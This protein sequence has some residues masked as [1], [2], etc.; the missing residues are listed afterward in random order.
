VWQ[1]KGQ[2]VPADWLC[3]EPVAVLYD[4]D[5][6]TIFT[7]KDVDGKLYLAYQCS[8]APGRM[9]FLVVP[10]SEESVRRLSIGDLNLHDALMRPRACLIDLDYQG[11]VLAAWETLPENLPPKAIPA[12][13]VMLWSHLTPKIVENV[14][15][16]GS[17]S[18]TRIV[19]L[20]PEIVDA[21]R[22]VVAS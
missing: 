10:F 22:P 15:R 2:S 21:F 17:T 12:P 13:G 11:D 20:S 3:L 7:C 1:V 9:R 5:G 14:P 4:F 16:P 19:K 8:E 18:M 6:P